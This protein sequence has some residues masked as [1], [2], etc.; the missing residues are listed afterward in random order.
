MLTWSCLG[1]PFALV[2]TST[3]LARSLTE[4]SPSKTMC[5]VLSIVSLKELVCWGVGSLLLCICS[6]LDQTFWSLCHRRHV[7]AL[8]C[9][10]CIRLIRTGII[11]CFCFCQSSTYPSCGCSWSIW[12]SQF[13]R[14]FLPTPT[15]VW[16]LIVTVF[17]TGTL[18]GLKGAVNHWLLPWV[19][20]SVFRGVGACGVAKEIYKQFF[21]FSLGPVLLVFI[22]IIMIIITIIIITA[23]DYSCPHHLL[24][25]TANSRCWQQLLTAA[26]GSNCRQ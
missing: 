4:G 15:R 9:V 7:A 23:A 17:N 12:T 8:F 13:T 11:V 22:I 5:M 21:F 10:C 20:F 25:T 24:T 18:D 2:P 3:F 14:Y 1:F 26:V 16:N 6:C 19:C